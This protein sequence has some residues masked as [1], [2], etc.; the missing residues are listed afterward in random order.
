MLQVE[1]AQEKCAAFSLTT[2]VSQLQKHLAD[3]T[4]DFHL[5]K[6]GHLL[7][8]SLWEQL[9]EGTEESHHQQQQQEQQEGCQEEQQRQQHMR[10]EAGITPRSAQLCSGRYKNSW[11]DTSTSLRRTKNSALGTS[12]SRGSFKY[13]QLSSPS[14]VHMKL[15][16]M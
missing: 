3:T 5:M 10:E 9:E 12:N 14:A 7:L 2:K 8:P 11:R 4:R 15:I 13:T 1:L 16:T 6:S